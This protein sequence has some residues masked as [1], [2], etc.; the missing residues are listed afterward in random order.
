MMWT[1][2]IKDKNFVSFSFCKNIFDEGYRSDRFY[3]KF[4]KIYGIKRFHKTTLNIGEYTPSYEPVPEGSELDKEIK[5]YIALD[6]DYNLPTT[7]LLVGILHDFYESNK[8]ESV[9]YIFTRY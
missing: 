2:F 5:E 9:R 3:I 4:E 7:P 8:Y 6:K 1:A